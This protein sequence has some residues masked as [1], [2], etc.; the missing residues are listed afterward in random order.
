MYAAMWKVI[1]GLAMMAVGLSLIDTTMTLAAKSTAPPLTKRQGNVLVLSMP[2][3]S[4]WFSLVNIAHELKI[5]GYN[6]TFVFPDVPGRQ[7][8]TGVSKSDII[9]SE[10]MNKFVRYFRE[11]IAVP[12]IK[13]GT[14]TGSAIPLSYLLRFNKLCPFVASDKSLLKQLEQ[15]HFDLV[16]ID[17][18]F[19]NPCLS[20]IP[21]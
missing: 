19:E 8:I 17:T 16:I 14:T 1:Q 2:A 20:V 12:F 10:G 21:Y 5:I 3:Y 6:T 18:N 7:H 4:R 11:N 9:V 13:H 15:R